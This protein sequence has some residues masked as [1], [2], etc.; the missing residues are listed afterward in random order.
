MLPGSLTHSLEPIQIARQTWR[1]NYIQ[2]PFHWLSILEKVQDSLMTKE[3]DDDSPAL[4]SSFTS[5]ILLHF[6]SLLD[7]GNHRTEQNNRFSWRWRTLGSC[8]LLHYLVSEIKMHSWMK[9]L[10]LSCRLSLSFLLFLVVLTQLFFVAQLC[11]LFVFRVRCLRSFLFA[12]S[13]ELFL[14]FSSSPPPSL[15]SFH[16]HANYNV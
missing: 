5:T 16:S 13:L 3:M 10:S 7:K 2:I 12:S 8:S 1:E 11:V 6:F 4:F 15:A 14:Y 9:N